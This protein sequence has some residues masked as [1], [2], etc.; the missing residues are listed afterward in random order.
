VFDKALTLDFTLVGMG[1]V[2]IVCDGLLTHYVLDMSGFEFNPMLRILIRKVGV[3]TALV[4]SR[5]AALLV[6]LVVSVLMD[7]IVLIL[8]VMIWCVA[9]AFTAHSALMHSSAP[10][11]LLGRLNL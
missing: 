8:T 3:W 1:I 11:R 10:R 7:H 2:A 5:I 4:I 9:A 6:L